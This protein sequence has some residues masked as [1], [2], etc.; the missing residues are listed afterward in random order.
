MHTI[1]P[2]SSLVNPDAHYLARFTK[3]ESG[4]IVCI[5]I[6]GIQVDRPSQKPERFF[7][8]TA[9][10]ENLGEKEMQH[11]AVRIMRQGPPELP[12]CLVEMTR[13]FLGDAAFDKQ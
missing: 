4:E 12:L 2:D 10:V 13:R 1:S 5:R 8:Q 11:R 6:C 3:D 9:I 7:A